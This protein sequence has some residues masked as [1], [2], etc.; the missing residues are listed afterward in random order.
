MS[1]TLKIYDANN[2]YY[3]PSGST[4]TSTR[5][6]TVSSQTYGVLVSQW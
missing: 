6:V 4:L 2:V 5:K 3:S 1:L